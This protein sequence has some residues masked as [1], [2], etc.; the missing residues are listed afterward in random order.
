MSIN[1][2]LI[3][4]MGK[5]EAEVHDR[6]YSLQTKLDNVID[7]LKGK[8]SASAKQAIGKEFGNTNSVFHPNSLNAF[9]HNPNYHP[10]GL[11][12]KR[13]WNNIEPL[14]MAIWE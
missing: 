2:H 5:T 11:D 14:I 3:T 12:L 10:S 4:N 6:K 7:N 1:Q 9:V 8:V 13:G